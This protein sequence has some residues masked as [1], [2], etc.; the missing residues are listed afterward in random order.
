MPL[1][2]VAVANN[3][4]CLTLTVTERG[5]HDAQAAAQA[6]KP[7]FRPEVKD[8]QAAKYHLH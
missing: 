1:E 6:A 2:N 5:L 4:E 8:T 7:I 3:L